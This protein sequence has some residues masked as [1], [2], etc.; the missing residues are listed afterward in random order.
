MS[1]IS[2]IRGFLHTRDEISLNNI[3]KELWAVIIIF[4]ISVILANMRHFDLDIEFAGFQSFELMLFLWGFGWLVLALFPKRF[5]FLLLKIAATISAVL[6]LFQ[7]L[8][9]ADMPSRLPGVQLS[10]FM[11]YMFF[12]GICCACAFFLFCF[13]LNN[14]ERMAGIIL[15]ICYHGLD[16]AVF[17]TFPA[18]QKIYETWCG[19]AVMVFFLVL[20]FLFNKKTSEI[21]INENK[22]TNIAQDIK[23][24]KVGIIIPLHIVYF[25]TMMMIHYLEPAEN[26]IFSLPYGLGQFISIIFTVLV[27]VLLNRNPL[28]IWLS[29]LVF[30]LFGLSIVNYNSAAA[31]FSGSLVFGTGDGL[32]YIITI[33]LCAGEIK[34][35]K[36]IKMYRLYCFILF[37]E[38]VF[39]SGILSKVF[40]YF[41][42]STHTVAFIIVLV[43]CSLC[44]LI[45]PYLQKKLFSEDWTDGLSVADIPEYIPALEQAEKA[46]KEDNLGLTPREKD[47][48]ALLMQNMPL[49]TIALELGITFNTVNSHYRSIYRK[50][51]ITS[52]GELFLKY[53]I[54]T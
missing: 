48:F 34:K 49:K 30:T 6:L 45:L 2:A 31:Q 9:T 42:E 12:N 24:A 19:I 26:I 27:M 44:F 3:R 38:Y 14:V 16:F 29:F 33:Y 4:P 15:L 8:L 13:N 25:T 39:I 5:I 50:L 10:V 40:N 7:I 43:L 22:N 18:V 53:K 35:S 11:A 23:E 41:A 51:G 37:I 32:G 28:Y 36:S 20:V 17:K 47:V 1:V 54:K 21:N 46:D 52:K